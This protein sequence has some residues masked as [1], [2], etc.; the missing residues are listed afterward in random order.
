MFVKFFADFFNKI[1]KKSCVFVIKY[2]DSELKRWTREDSK[3][4]FE[5]KLF[6]LLKKIF[7]EVSV[8]FLVNFKYFS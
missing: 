5:K 2:N 6:G 1:T 4:N 7:F 8:E 3:G